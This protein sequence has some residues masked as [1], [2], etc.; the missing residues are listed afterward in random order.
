MKRYLVFVRDRYTRDAQAFLAGTARPEED[1]LEDEFGWR[2]IAA[3]ALVMDRYLK[4]PDQLKTLL[5]QLYP[6][7]DPSVFAVY[8]AE[9]LEE[10][11]LS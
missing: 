9:G 8:A 10:V 7:T 2:D 4:G 6:E 1:P 5:A 3:P 11:S